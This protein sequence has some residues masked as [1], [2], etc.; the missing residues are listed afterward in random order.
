MQ[1]SGLL[2]AWTIRTIVLRHQRKPTGHQ[3]SQ[4]PEPSSLPGGSSG[5][6]P[7]T[8]RGSQWGEE[9]GVYPGVTSCAIFSRFL[10]TKVLWF[11]SP[12]LSAELR[13]RHELVLLASRLSGSLLTTTLAFS[14]AYSDSQDHVLLSQAEG[15]ASVQCSNL[16]NGSGKQNSICHISTQV[17][18][19]SRVS[20]NNL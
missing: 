8:P 16:G 9:A 19:E 13:Q 15:C 14:P 20:H 1:S 17:L 18:C 11:L 2:L 10:G 4:C 12:E 5:M 6:W 3:R 7:G